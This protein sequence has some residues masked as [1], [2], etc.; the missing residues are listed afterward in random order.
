MKIELEKES[1]M[2]CPKCN[3]VTSAMVGDECWKC[4]DSREVETP[5]DGKVMNRFEKR[6]G[7]NPCDECRFMST[8]KCEDF[9]CKDC[10]QNVETQHRK[11]YNGGKFP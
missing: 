8:K 1:I 4:Y 11:G 10:N 9:P 3:Q 7:F 6:F 2:K 5:D